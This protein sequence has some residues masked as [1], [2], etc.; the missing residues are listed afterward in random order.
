[1][2]DQQRPIRVKTEAFL[3]LQERLPE[4]EGHSISGPPALAVAQMPGAQFSIAHSS[5]NERGAVDSASQSELRSMYGANSSDSQF[6]SQ[7]GFSKSNLKERFTS[8][9]S[10]IHLATPDRVGSNFD[11]PQEGLTFLPIL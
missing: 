5:R 2:C 7:S 9:R 11:P 8:Q 10:A 3:L 4:I 1:V 6:H